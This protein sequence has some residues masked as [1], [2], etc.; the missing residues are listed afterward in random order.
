MVAIQTTEAWVEGKA[1]LEEVEAAR[2]AAYN[3]YAAI[4]DDAIDD[5]DAF[6][7]Y[8]SAYYTAHTTIN[9]KFAEAVVDA[10]SLVDEEKESS[11]LN[12]A[13]IIREFF[14]KSPF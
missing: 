4:N 12:S 1:T 11:L 14:P 13:N 9:I 8:R 10:A 5:D 7:A 2:N 3:A 6:S